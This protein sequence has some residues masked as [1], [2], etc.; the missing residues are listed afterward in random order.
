MTSLII[1]RYDEDT[2]WLKNYKNFKIIVYNKGNVIPEQN[3]FIINNIPNIGRE[4]HTWL[5]HIVKNY[6]NLDEYNLFLQGR[7]DDLGCMA[8]KD[9]NQY[10]KELK[11]NE[12]SV[13]RFGLLGPFHW[14]YHIGI[15]NDPKYES[16]WIKGEITRSKIG[17]RKFAKKYFPEIPIFVSTSY[18][19]C[20]GV[21]RNLLLK[22]EIDF[23]KSLLDEVS[24]S[25]HPIEAHY[26]ERL[27]C[28]MFTNN[29]FLP[30]T[31]TDITRTKIETL[32]RKFSI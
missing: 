15:E 12:F 7:I 1:S 2:S 25:C 27:W 6:N 31:L 24:Q 16:R 4:A 32:F 20:F 18:G 23:Y 22:Y 5:Y 14:G 8:Y 13:S 19:G 11:K 30:R 3:N 10:K 9:L 28:Y 29:R 17:F 26:L 21:S